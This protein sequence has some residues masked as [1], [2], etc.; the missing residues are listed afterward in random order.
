MLPTVRLPFY[1]LDNWQKRFLRQLDGVPIPVLL[2]RL[3]FTGLAAEWSKQERQFAEHLRYALSSLQSEIDDPAL[4]GATLSAKVFEMPCHP[5]D[6]S[7]SHT[8]ALIALQIVLDINTTIRSRVCEF[9]PLQF[10]KVRQM[11]HEN[12]PFHAAFSHSLHRELA[13]VLASLPPKPPK[14]S[15]HN[16]S[17]QSLWRA[18]DEF[19]LPTGMLSPHSGRQSLSSDDLPLRRD[20]KLHKG[21]GQSQL[22]GILSLPGGRHQHS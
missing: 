8:C 13:A 20:G 19:G 7:H 4:D 11:V 15:L 2:R 1:Q 5:L 6:N 18:E 12:S 14:P 21:Q 22:G 3:A 9:T 16:A 17:T 10:F